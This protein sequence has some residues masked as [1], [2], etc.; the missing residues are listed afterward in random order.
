MLHFSQPFLKFC[1]EWPPWR[2]EVSELSTSETGD[3]RVDI[4]Q[5][6]RDRNRTAEKTLLG[7]E[8]PLEQVITPRIYPGVRITQDIYPEVS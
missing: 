8:T 1:Q 6:F 7:S 4:S 5:Q 3:R 2:L